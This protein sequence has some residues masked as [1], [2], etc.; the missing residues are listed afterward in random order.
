MEAVNKLC[1]CR[2]EPLVEV[3]V[4]EKAVVWT[5]KNYYDGTGMYMTHPPAL[6]LCS[7]FNT[8][9]LPVD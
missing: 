3:P 5:S 8:V 7:A 6:K 9:A 4:P 2:F 1:S